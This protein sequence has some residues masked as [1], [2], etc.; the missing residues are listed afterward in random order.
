M[1]GQN[2][3]TAHVV[4]GPTRTTAGRLSGLS[5]SSSL[6]RP[7][8]SCL[9]PI[10]QID[11][12]SS[13]SP[14]G[15]RATVTCL[16]GRQLGPSERL[17]CKWAARG[18]GA[19]PAPDRWKA[20]VALAGLIDQR[21]AL[22][23]ND[24]LRPGYWLSKRCWRQRMRQSISLAPRQQSN[25]LNQTKPSKQKPGS[26]LLSSRYSSLNFCQKDTR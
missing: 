12:S 4:A 24:S 17:Q 19:I 25:Q 5:S 26:L 8:S 11:M 7:I 18:E 15:G 22:T 10:K 9:A 3:R 14:D 21:S 20:F 13:A 6:A 1:A 2:W 16:P 23:Q